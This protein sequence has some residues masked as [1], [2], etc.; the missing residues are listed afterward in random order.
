MIDCEIPVYHLN[1]LLTIS[2]VW[3]V[4]PIYWVIVSPSLILSWKYG[5]VAILI[6]QS[7]ASAAQH[8]TERDCSPHQMHGIACANGVEHRML[9]ADRL[10]A[11]SVS[12]VYVGLIWTHVGISIFL[13][14]WYALYLAW[15]MG[16]IYASDNHIRGSPVWYTAIH[17][18][19]HISIY[20]FLGDI[21]RWID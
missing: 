14:S 10:M 18:V 5:L 12:V 17:L 8:I 9:W 21:V 2:N 16:L 15:C 13:S 1:V 20:S 4:Y 6:G 3:V 11:G 7:I 19:W